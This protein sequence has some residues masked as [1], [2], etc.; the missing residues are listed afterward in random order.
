MS[1]FKKDWQANAPTMADL[2][3]NHNPLQIPSSD[4]ILREYVLGGPNCNRDV[5]F[6]IDIETLRRLVEVAEQSSLKRACMYG[7]GIKL[8]VHRS[9]Q[10]HVYETLHLTGYA[11]VPESAPNQFVTKLERS[12]FLGDSV[13]KDWDRQK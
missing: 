6:L 12:T 2:V 4:P 11:P 7:A 1:K 8:K 10:G 9:N 3:I 5:R 13:I